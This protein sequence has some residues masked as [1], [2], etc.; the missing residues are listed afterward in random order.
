[1]NTEKFFVYIIQSNKDFSFYIG[2]T[3][4]LDSRLNKHNDGLSKYTSS[5]VPWRLVYFEMHI[6]RAE[7]IKRE[8]EIKSKKSKKYLEYLISNKFSWVSEWLKGS[9]KPSGES[10]YMGNC[11]VPMS[12]DESLPLCWYEKKRLQNAISFFCIYISFFKNLVYLRKFLRLGSLKIS[13]HL[14]NGWFW[15]KAR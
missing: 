11:I 15:I 10:V 7:A 8:K 3:N 6:T 1:M 14:T 4:D 12:R 2:Q 5:K 13:T 9:R